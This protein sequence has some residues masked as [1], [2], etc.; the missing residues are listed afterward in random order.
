MK[1]KNAA[2]RSAVIIVI[3]LLSVLIGYIY[4]LIWHNI[5][6]KNH[7]REYSEYVTKYS[8]EYGVP[9]YIVYAVILQESNFKSNYLSDD[10]RIGLMQISPDKF[11]WL[12]S[13]TKEDL[14]EGILYDPDTNIRYGTYMLSYLYTEY[15][16]WNAVLAAYETDEEQIN[17][18]LS[19]SDNTDENGN[20]IRIPDA[21]VSE[22]VQNIENK[23]DTY[24]NLYYDNN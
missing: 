15:G 17:V 18:W 19:N 10:G 23:I 8:Q 5:D 2:K 6:L 3:I 4:H 20:L 13:L 7:P 16:R 24:F 22:K 9:E 12:L 14:D 21:Y 1:Y 11:R